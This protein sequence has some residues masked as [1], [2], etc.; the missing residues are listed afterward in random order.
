MK[1]NKIGQSMVEYLMLLVIVVGAIIV[2]MVKVQPRVEYAYSGL[3]KAM[4]D[5]VGRK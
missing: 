1:K 3:S 2:A 5:K 4:V